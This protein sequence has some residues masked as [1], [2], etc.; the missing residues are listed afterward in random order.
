MSKREGTKID[1]ESL[2][3][4]KIESMLITASWFEEIRHILG[5]EAVSQVWSERPSWYF[6]VSGSAGVY[7]LDLQR[8]EKE[9]VDG[10]AVYSAGFSIKCYPFVH[11]DAFGCFSF[12]ERCYIRSGFFDHTNTPS[13]EDQ[14]QIP[15]NL[16]AIAALQ[17]RCD[18]NDTFSLFTFESL[19]TMRLSY[20]GEM[21]R[22]YPSLKKTRRFDRGVV[23]RRVPG[24]QI[25]YPFFD[26]LICLHTFHSKKTPIRVLISRSQG[27]EHV[28]DESG[29]VICA[30]APDTTLSTV[31]ILYGSGNG[32]TDMA[33]AR[34]LLEAS[35]ADQRETVLDRSF[36]ADLHRCSDADALPSTP[37]NCRWWS[38][39]GAEYSCEIASSCGC[40]ET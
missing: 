32:C 29:D 8:A 34:S 9:T 7:H 11:A 21:L 31:N 38:L 12:E 5:L 1:V 23:D 40:M 17:Y 27:F 26:R 13:F 3:R 25:G 6:W 36:D 4:S 37:L 16:F 18:E 22:S 30:D 10:T 28:V 33:L 24:T 35:V 15:E 20:R 39:A 19:D 2:F 14:G